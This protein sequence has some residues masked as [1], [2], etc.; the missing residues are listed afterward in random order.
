MQEIMG[1]EKRFLELIG[2]AREGSRPA[3]DEL[4]AEITASLLAAIRRGIGEGLGAK[5]EPEDVL[6]ETLLRAFKSI[7]HFRWQGELSFRR[8]LEGSASNIPLRPARTE[9]RKRELQ[10]ERDPPASGVSPSRDARRVERFDRLQ[11]SIDGLSPDHQ[12]VIR[13]ARLEGLKIQEIAERMG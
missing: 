8:E 7:Q 4:A 13:L 1:A 10:M 12:T 3:F 5:L 6:Q 9:V 2:R 11:R